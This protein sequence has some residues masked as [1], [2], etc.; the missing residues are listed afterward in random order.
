MPLNS[1]ADRGDLKWQWP[2]F[3]LRTLLLAI[4]AYALLVGGLLILS[5]EED[6]IGPS[7]GSL[8]LVWGFFC[9]YVV[10]LNRNWITQKLAFRRR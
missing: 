3:S 5:E 8:I 1:E 2:R 9:W 4:A 6:A 7:I 10:R